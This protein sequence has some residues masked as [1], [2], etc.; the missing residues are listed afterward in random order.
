M[1]TPYDMVIRKLEKLEGQQI[2]DAVF[3]LSQIRK[4]TIPEVDAEAIEKE[5]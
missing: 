4:M 3:Y 2:S 1:E 5:D